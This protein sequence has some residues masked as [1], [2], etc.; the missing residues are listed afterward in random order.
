MSVSAPS[1]AAPSPAAP[2]S[3]AA[4]A[5]RAFADLQQR[6]A[7]RRQ[8]LLLHPLYATVDS[9]PRLRAFMALHAFAVWDFMS[10]VKRLQGELC[11]TAVPWCPPRDPRLAR[12]LNEIVLG[13][14]SDLG[15]DG[16]PTSHLAAYRRA[17]A[18]VGAD[19][20]GIAAVLAALAAGAS[21]A[22]ALALP[23]VPAVA[24]RFCG[25]TLAL[26]VEG[27]APE[28]A[29]AFLFGREDVIP[30]MFQALLDR[31]A[32]GWGAPDQTRWMRWYLDRHIE[33][34]GEE[35]GPMAGALLC[36]LCG[37]DPAAWAAAEAAAVAAITARIDLWD[38]ILAS[39]PPRGEP[40]WAPDEATTGSVRPPA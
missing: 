23:A 39:L 11:G 9:L 5:Q 17:M 38:G 30:E 12:F 4:A 13:E 27:S 2:P 18:E 29:A 37:D 28:V 20:T 3:P 25:Q 22:A 14:E 19:D 8:D 26:A 35:H 31:G 24:A 15:P 10:L 1:S 36:R 6:L 33:L 21:P 32:A 16:A 40:G 7:P 34:D